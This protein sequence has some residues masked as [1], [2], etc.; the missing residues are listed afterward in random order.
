ML[1]EGTGRA[2]ADRLSRNNEPHGTKL[3]EQEVSLVFVL[4][5]DLAIS[6]GMLGQ[7]YASG[8]WDQELG[9]GWSF[10][11]HNGCEGKAPAQA[12]VARCGRIVGLL[13]PS[14]TFFSEGTRA[15]DSFVREVTAAIAELEQLEAKLS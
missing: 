8:S 14:T 13:T 7:I 6:C 10:T 3:R 15:R 2:V 5:I 4:L 9:G 1:I 12:H 11:L